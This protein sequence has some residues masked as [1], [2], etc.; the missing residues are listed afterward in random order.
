MQAWLWQASGT[1]RD[2]G[3]SWEQPRLLGSA[4]VLSLGAVAMMTVA[5][6]D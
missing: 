4:A 6:R 1:T 2:G 5:N 3:G